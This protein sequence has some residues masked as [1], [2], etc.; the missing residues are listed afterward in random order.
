[1]YEPFEYV[2]TEEE[3]RLAADEGRRRQR[4]NE[5]KKRRGRNGAPDVG[6][7]SL[8]YNLIGAAGEM[9]VA[10]YLGLKKYVYADKEPVRGSFDLP[11]NIEVKTSTRYLNEMPVQLDDVKTKRYVHVTIEKNICTIHGWTTA[12]KAMKPLHIKEPQE[13]RPAYFVPKGILY[14][15]SSLLEIVKSLNL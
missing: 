10:S 5:K 8:H 13:N 9:A 12:D 14:S 15:M 1:M 3:R 2:F 7:K 4:E 6:K 11:P